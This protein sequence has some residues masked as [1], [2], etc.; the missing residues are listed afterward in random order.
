MR[1]TIVVTSLETLKYKIIFD[2][3]ILM[4]SLGP[5]VSDIKKPN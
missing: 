2:P 3:L 1:K 5:S 4:I